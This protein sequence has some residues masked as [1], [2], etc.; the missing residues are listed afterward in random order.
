MKPCKICE[1]NK[2]HYGYWRR[3]KE[4]DRCSLC[5]NPMTF[6]SIKVHETYDYSRTLRHSTE[7]IGEDGEVYLSCA[8][9]KFIGFQKDPKLNKRLNKKLARSEFNSTLHIIDLEE[10]VYKF[11]HDKTPYNSYETLCDMCYSRLQYKT[12]EDLFVRVIEHK[13]IEYG[14]DPDVRCCENLVV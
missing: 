3:K 14:K 13:E 1:N 10:P 8:C 2:D 12:N 4:V 11:L 7:F 9:S 6:K 5:Q